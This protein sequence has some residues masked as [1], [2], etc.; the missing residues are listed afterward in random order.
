M[1]LTDFE[2]QVYAALDCSWVDLHQIAQSLYGLTQR[3]YARGSYRDVPTT[4]SGSGIESML[5]RLT[6][7]GMVEWEPSPLAPMGKKWRRTL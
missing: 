6:E 3:V 7:K 4:A 1:T 5:D 2:E